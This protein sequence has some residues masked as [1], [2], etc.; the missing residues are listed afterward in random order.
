MKKA[1]LVFFLTFLFQVS[2]GQN[3]AFIN[4]EP[5]ITG[6][7]TDLAYIKLHV[8]NIGTVSQNVYAKRKIQTLIKVSFVISKSEF[9][10]FAYSD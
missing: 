5:A 4:A 6:N 2:F 10:S 3:L 8:K 7:D 9:E 1:L